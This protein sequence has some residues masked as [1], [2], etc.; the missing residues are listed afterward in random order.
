MKIN[1]QQHDDYEA[2]RGTKCHMQRQ[3]AVCTCM[4]VHVSVRVCA[5]LCVYVQMHLPFYAPTLSQHN[6]KFCFYRK[7]SQLGFSFALLCCTLSCLAQSCPFP[8][9]MRLS[10]LVCACLCLSTL[11]PSLSH[12]WLAFAFFQFANRWPQQLPFDHQLTP[13]L[14]PCPLPPFYCPSPL[15]VSLSLSLSCCR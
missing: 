5:C 6:F 15:A 9:L 12:P 7:L 8:S 11:V 13:R 10:L 1:L 3:S 14:L 4:F 2:R